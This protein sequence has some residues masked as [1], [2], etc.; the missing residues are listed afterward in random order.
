MRGGRA[1]PKFFG[2]FSRG[3]FLVNKR[4]REK[5]AQVV[6][7]WG[8]EGTVPQKRAQ[9]RFQADSSIFKGSIRLDWDIS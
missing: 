7:I 6:Q 9:F 3:A 2:T 8:R 4:R 1:L 5:V